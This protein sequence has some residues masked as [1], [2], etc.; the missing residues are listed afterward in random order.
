MKTFIATLIILLPSLLFSSALSDSASACAV[1]DFIVLPT[2][3]FGTSL[4][5]HGSGNV[6]GY[7]DKGVWDSDD[8]EV[9]FV[10]SGYGVKSRHIRY[11]ESTNTWDIV[12]DSGD[13]PWTKVEASLHGYEH[14]AIDVDG[15]YLYHRPQATTSAWRWSLDTDLEDGV[16]WVQSSS[17]SGGSTSNYGALS[18]FPETD[19]LFFNFVNRVVCYDWGTSS[20]G[21]DQTPT[22]AY[23]NLSVYNPVYKW[24]GFGGGTSNTDFYKYDSL[25]DITQLEDFPATARVNNSVWSVDP[26]SGKYILLTG[27]T[28]YEY[29]PGT[30]NW[31]VLSGTPDPYSYGSAG[32]GSLVIAIPIDNYGV[33]MF[34]KYNGASS[35]VWLYKHEAT[36]GAVLGD[37]AHDG[38]ATP[39]QISLLLPVN[40]DT[41]A[42]LTATV[43]YKLS[44]SGTYLNAHPMHRIMPN[45][46]TA[47]PDS[48]FAGVIWDLEPNSIYNIRVTVE[49]AHENE[50]KTLTTTTRALP[51]SAGAYTDTIFAGYNTTQIQSAIDALSP[52]DVLFWE[53]DT[54]ELSTDLD[55]DGVQG[56]SSQLIYWVG[57]DRD[58]TVIK[59]DGGRAIYLIDTDYLVFQN[60]TLLGSF[61]GTGTDAS[62]IAFQ[63][64][65]GNTQSYLTFRNLTVKGVD[66]G[67]YAPGILE[68]ILVYDCTWEGNNTWDV[69][70]LTQQ[71]YWND[72]GL[73]VPGE[74]N[75]VFNNTLTGFGDTFAMQDGVTSVGIHFY[76][77]DVRMTGDDAFEAD[78]GWRNITFYDNR[79][80][81]SMTFV[82]CD[83]I[84]GGP[85]FVFRNISINTGRAPYKL[86]DTNSGHFFYN[87]TVVRTEGTGS[88]FGWG[89][90]Q[91]SN[92]A[93]RAW[94]MR[95]NILIYRGAGR[96]MAMESATNNPIDFTNNAWFP[97][98]TSVW[99]TNSGGSFDSVGAAYSGLSSTT[100]WFSNSTERHEDYQSSESDPFVTN[101]VLDANYG[102]EIT[103]TYT[104]TLTAGSAPDSNG[105]E[106]YGVTDGYTD[107]SPDMGA[108]ITGRSPVEYGE[109]GAEATAGTMK[110]LDGA[111]PV[112]K[113]AGA[114]VITN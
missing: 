42:A 83:P 96:M 11:K 101:I 24:I 54:F 32:L 41:L 79:I 100:P 92:G 109:R 45:Y 112:E 34:C 17:Y 65:N 13:C 97:A 68:G 14:T 47:N 36:A 90:A 40:K 35:R 5:D 22:Q 113:V 87:N 69:D 51:A 28:W 3:N 111:G 56:T 94:G 4:L 53:K 89:W 31:S 72:D 110:Q 84:N 103:I 12:F 44:S 19:S 30:D 67:I 57:E 82:S 33:I 63:F 99:W 91:S 73:Q 15:R 29:N 16:G 50:I 60:F 81:N 70:S 61:D 62:G 105:V 64:Y 37:L 77:N 76:R 80:H 6:F 18:Y 102:T 39:E 25:G 93:Q 48:D 26:V 23:Q 106:I 1:G 43:E 55:L 59:K 85:L 78:Y 95:N 74:G 20:Y 2:T 10:G 7:C 114:G 104:P 49:V 75:C 58:S 66:R 21:P 107:P 86:N 9:H 108:I 88:G 52:G 71:N 38:P 46:I 8:A 27:S 98:D